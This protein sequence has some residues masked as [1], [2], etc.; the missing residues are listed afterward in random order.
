PIKDATLEPDE[1]IVVQIVAGSGYTVG[2]ANSATATIRADPPPPLPKISIVTTDAVGTEDGNTITFTVNRDIGIDA[3]LTVALQYSGT[4]TLGVD[5][6][7]TASA[8]FPSGS[9]TATITT[10]PIQDNIAEADETT[11]ATL[12]AR[13]AY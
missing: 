13:S 1:T 7:A 11:I 9:S 2:A 5:Y 6:E 4:A 12:I 10:A 8:T 3:A